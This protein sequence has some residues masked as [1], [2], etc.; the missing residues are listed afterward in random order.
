MK[1][2]G[3][4][5]SEF[6]DREDGIE[7]K[8]VSEETKVDFVETHL[9]ENADKFSQVMEELA[10]HELVSV[11]MNVYENR[12][13]KLTPGDVFE[14][15][16]E[17]RFVEPSEID[18]VELVK[19]ELLLLN[20][21]PAGF[22]PIE[23]SPLAPVGS[24]SVLTKVNSKTVLQTIRNLEVINDTSVSLALESAKRK[25]GDERWKTPDR[26]NIDTV[27]FANLHRELRVQKF[28][29]KHLSQ[30]FASFSL[31]SSGRD[32]GR[33]NFEKQTA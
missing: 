32:T 28:S 26:R 18:V 4:I 11:L 16:S 31:T 13:K 12:I 19:T 6:S 8:D 33:Q 17:N 1:F 9:G 23:L 2:E 25:T 10:S 5:N 14:N 30:H 29:Q 20:N 15:Y 22:E 7:K 21:L 3:V 27:N 24:S